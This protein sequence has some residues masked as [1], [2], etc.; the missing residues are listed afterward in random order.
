[1]KLKMIQHIHRE[2]L[3]F[4]RFS[5]THVLQTLYVF[6]R[7]AKPIYLFFVQSLLVECYMIIMGE[8]KVVMLLLFFFLFMFPVFFP[9]C[10]FCCIIQIQTYWKIVDT[11]SLHLQM[12]SLRK[13]LS[14][15]CNT[16]VS[17]QR[18]HTLHHWRHSHQQPDKL[19]LRFCSDELP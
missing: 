16:S 15:L 4:F 2:R 6:I 14:N 18:K 8:L 9:Q 5:I 12:W 7:V 10:S 3:L 11:I 19:W 1:M 17:V 13:W